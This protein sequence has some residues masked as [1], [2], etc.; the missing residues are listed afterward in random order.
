MEK[1]KIKIV[2][3]YLVILF[4]LF[5]IGS[6]LVINPFFGEINVIDEGQFGAWMRHMLH[7]EFLYNDTYS[8]YETLYIYPFYLFLIVR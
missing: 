4:F 1:N 3:E 6:S 7:G 8:E 5:F 2:I